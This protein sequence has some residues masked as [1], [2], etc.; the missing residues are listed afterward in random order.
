M[1]A[2]R[3]ARLRRRLIALISS[4][5]VLGIWLPMATAQ[6]PFAKGKT[7]AV[8]VGA[9]PSSGCATYAEENQCRYRTDAG[10]GATDLISRAHPIRPG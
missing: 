3:M 9:N 5:V 1:L 2:P 8:I 10:R 7:V 4:A 6:Q